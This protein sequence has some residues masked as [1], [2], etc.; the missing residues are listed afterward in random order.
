VGI[1]THYWAKRAKGDPDKIDLVKQMLSLLEPLF[2]ER[3][4]NAVKGIAWGLK[5]IGRYYPDLLTDWLATEIIPTDRKHRAIM[6]RKALTFLTPDQQARVT[7]GV[8]S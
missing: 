8:D 1:A 3:E 2:T 5:T 6:L 4:I 7:R